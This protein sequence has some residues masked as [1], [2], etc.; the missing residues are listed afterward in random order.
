MVKVFIPLVLLIAGFSLGLF[1]KDYSKP[2]TTPDSTL[3]ITPSLMP[4]AIPSPT[5]TIVQEDLSTVIQKSIADKYK[6]TDLGE[7]SVTVGKQTPDFAEGTVSLSD[8]G[9]WWLAAKTSGHWKLVDD[10][11]GIVSCEKISPYNFP[12]SMVPQCVDKQGNLIK[13]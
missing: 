5:I 7:I 12:S 10:G 9:G 6:L 4:T 3:Q 11:N 8:G 13:K 2:K 1:I